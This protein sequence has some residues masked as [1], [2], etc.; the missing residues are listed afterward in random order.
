[1]LTVTCVLKT[2]GDYD[3]EHL[4]R[5][6]RLALPFLPDGFLWQPVLDSPCPGWWSK[7]SLFEP[8]RFTG[9]VLYLDLDTT[10]C[11]QLAD[12]AAVEGEFVIC[13]DYATLGFNSSVMAW[14]AGTCDDI[15]HG[16]SPE[17]TEWFR[18]D[19]NYIQAKRPGAATFP[20]VWVPSWK[21]TVRPQGVLSPDARVCVHH[22]RPRPWELPADYLEAYR[23]G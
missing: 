12:L 5:L 8:G 1:M 6:Y 23:V 16:F 22:G 19:Q 2:G 14:D 9:R 21:A 11:G 15:W 20:R 10:P 7:I 17:T 4:N 3:F 18:G 13:R